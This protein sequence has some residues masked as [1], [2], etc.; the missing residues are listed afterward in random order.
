MDTAAYCVC[1]ITPPPVTYLLAWWMEGG[2]GE[3]ERG[4]GIRSREIVFYREKDLKIERLYF[5]ERK[6][7]K[8]GDC[9]LQ[10]ERFENREIVFYREKDWKIGRLYF[11]ERKI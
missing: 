3:G 4:G 10:R 5:T 1:M 6:I 11:T 8:S 7:G 9:I 2:G